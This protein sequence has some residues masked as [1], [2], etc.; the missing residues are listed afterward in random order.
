MD[1]VL[2]REE[3]MWLQRLRIAWLR[4]RGVTQSFSIRKRSRA[5]KKEQDQAA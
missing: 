1:E 3:M 2:Y 4:E 5:G